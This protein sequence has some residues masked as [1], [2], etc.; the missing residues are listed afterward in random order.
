MTIGVVRGGEADLFIYSI[1][2]RCIDVTH[3]FVF[4]DIE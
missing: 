4:R 3:R 2:L 1:V